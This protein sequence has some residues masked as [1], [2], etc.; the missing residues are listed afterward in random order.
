MEQRSAAWYRE[1]AGRITGSRFARAMAS[2]QSDR[3]RNLIDQLVEERRTGR[4]RD[5]AYVNAAMQWGMD[6]EDR[7]R[8]WYGNS[9]G[10]AVQQIGFV[11]HPRYDY[12]GVSPDG[13]VAHDG[14]VE[15][16]CPQMKAFR[17]VMASR[18]IP[19]HYRWQVQG[20]LWVCDRQW[21]DFVCFYPPGQGICIRVGRNEADFARLAERCRQV[22]LEV[23]RRVRVSHTAPAVPRRQ[24][25]VPA[26]PNAWHGTNGEP[27]RVRESHAPPPAPRRQPVAPASPDASHDKNGEPPQSRKPGA[28]MWVWVVLGY[29]V[30]KL[31][32]HFLK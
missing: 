8:H 26:L 30:I 7:A 21:L 11:V 25:V 27:P 24:A 22:H 29:F 2:T 32:L 1:R 9:R 5:G 3:Y 6:H 31:L 16:K 4:C 19:S 13:L 14:L 28:L 12:V 20:Q 23:E 10:C 18:E 15:I 17:E